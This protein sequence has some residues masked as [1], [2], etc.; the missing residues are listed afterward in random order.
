MGRERRWGAILAFVILIIVGAALAFLLSHWPFTSDRVAKTLGSV[1]K[2]RVTIQRF[3]STYFPPGCV[4]EGIS[5]H[6]G[7][8]QGDIRRLTIA[9]GWPSLLTGRKR[10]N[11]ITAD[12]LEVRI[13]RNVGNANR[14]PSAG[15][16]DS[17]AS[18]LS[19]GEIAA[20]GAVLVVMRGDAG[21][22]P[23][24]FDIH[25]L[26]LGEVASGRPVPFR[27]ALRNPEPPGEIEASGQFGP[28]RT[29][30]PGKTPVSGSYTFDHAQLAVFHAIGGTLSSK[31]TFRGT[32]ERVEVKGT[33]Q[34]PDFEVTHAGHPVHLAA[35]FDAVVNGKNGD[36]TLE[37]VDAEIERTTIMSDG[38]IAG[39]KGVNGKFW[40]LNIAVRQ[41]YIQD[42]MR[43]LMR[44]DRPPMMGLITFRAKATVPPEQ[45]KFLEKLELS[46]DFGVGGS[47]FTTPSTQHNL[48]VLS[49]RARG[50][51]HDDADPEHVISDLKG[52]VVVRNGVARFSN[53][54]FAV[55]GARAELDG[56][57]NLLN[58][59]IDL[60]GKLAMLAELSQAS[61]GF[62]SFLLKALDPFYKKKTVGAVVPVSITGTYSRPVYAVIIAGKR[63][64]SMK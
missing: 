14:S 13:T 24:E 48:E 58:E 50:D 38:S 11:R 25:Q 34:L 60:H 54:S 22:P 31:G 62:K 20:D 44:S 23:L 30:E 35:R 43:L 27:A 18:K 59:R 45:R 29:D 57:F 28:L 40:E 10:V 55:P 46:G 37:P 8:A 61:K 5:F 41:G 4:A 21:K 1:F 2:S 16:G 26:R 47:R 19:V 49:E 12:G 39:K 32:L 3:R 56:T 64:S 15:G 33:T 63:T 53:L 52:H 9:A 17:N 51:K 7:H 6:D 36:T 42:L